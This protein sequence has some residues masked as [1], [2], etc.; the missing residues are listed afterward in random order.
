MVIFVVS[1]DK[2]NIGYTESI[3]HG[4]D[5][6]I[7]ITLDVEH[8]AVVGD[9]TGVSVYQLDISGC[10]PYR[11]LGILIP[12]LQRLSGIGMLFPEYP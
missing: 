7:A 12:G 4:Y 5:D 3:V 6:A 10:L 2:T 1:S 9:D 8:N 11:M